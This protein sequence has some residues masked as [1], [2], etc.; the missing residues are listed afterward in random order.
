MNIFYLSPDPRSCAR[1]HADIHVGKMCLETA[2]LL[3]T[4][5]RMLRGVQGTVKLRDKNGNV[6]EMTKWILPER[7]EYDGM[8]Y[9][10]RCPIYWDTHHNHPCA[11]WVR[12]SSANY[13]WAFLLFGELAREYEHRYG[14]VYK[15][16]Y[17]LQDELCDNPAP[18][19]TATP[20]ALA[21]PD[22]FKQ[23]GLA[24]PAYRAY[25]RSKQD[26]MRLVYTN[27]ELP[28]WLS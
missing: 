9:D 14:K 22:E 7:G 21:M 6:R 28:V 3:S 5:Y 11:Q 1:Q 10:E 17:L 13:E 26:S 19:G 12:M 18:Q 24:I 20:V 8:W 4:A 2:Q 27:R 23:D 25:Y 15:S 16:W